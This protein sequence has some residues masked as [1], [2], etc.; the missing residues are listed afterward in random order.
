MY[1]EGG[2]FTQ[3]VLGLTD[4]ITIGTCLDV[5]HL[6]GKGK[7]R[8]KRVPPTVCARLLLTEGIGKLPKSVLG[9]EHVGCGDIPAKGVYICF[10]KEALLANLPL[11]MHLGINSDIQDKRELYAFCAL[12]LSLN[13]ALQLLAEMDAIKIDGGKK[14]LK[15]VA[16]RYTI[17]PSLCIQF[18]L[19]DIEGEENRT[20]R[21]Q[22]QAPLF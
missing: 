11:S 17:L 3:V 22:Y 12:S 20:L 2:V 14:A 4:Q 1:G 5:E 9:Y 13:P 18:E 15:N 21:I 16:L 7:V 19:R 10:V 6:I 8:A